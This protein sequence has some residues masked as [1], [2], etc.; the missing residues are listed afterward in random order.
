M[1]FF[2]SKKTLFN[3]SDCV[4]VVLN[5]SPA[6]ARQYVLNHFFFYQ[7]PSV[8]SNFVSVLFSCTTFLLS[9]DDHQKKKYKKYLFQPHFLQPFRPKNLSYLESIFAKLSQNI[10]VNREKI[11]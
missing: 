3:R 2:L 11:F 9:S 10:H 7:V 4:M 8:K 5:P 1:F 6:L